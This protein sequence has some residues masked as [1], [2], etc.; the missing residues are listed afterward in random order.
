M[1]KKPITSMLKV[2]SIL[3][4]IQAV[5]AALAGVLALGAYVALPGLEEM[6]EQNSGIEITPLTYISIAIALVCGIIDIV[7]SVM[8]LQHKNLGLVYK[9]S[10]FTL[11]FSEVFSATD[12]KD[13]TDYT[14][15]IIGLIVPCLFLY[16]VFNQ[17]KLDGEN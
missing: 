10:I 15:I 14:S 17:K 5:F 4:I 12:L 13:V 7:M 8:A 11:I 16:A 6:V 2:T 3:H 1:E 9:I